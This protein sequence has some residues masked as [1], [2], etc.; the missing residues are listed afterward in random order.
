M[1]STRFEHKLSFCL[2]GFNPSRAQLTC[3]EVI[4]ARIDFETNSTSISLPDQ[5][6]GPNTDPIPLYTPNTNARMVRLSSG[7]KTTERSSTSSYSLNCMGIFKLM[8][9][10]FGASYTN[11]SNLMTDIES[12]IMSSTSR[13]EAVRHVKILK[14]RTEVS[15]LD[16][17]S[18]KLVLDMIGHNPKIGDQNCYVSTGCVICME[19]YKVG[20]VVGKCPCGHDFH[21]VCINEWYHIK[22]ECPL[23]RNHLSRSS[24]PFRLLLCL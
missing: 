10:R 18:E 4:R 17:A 3:G 21:G 1:D 20:S 9:K 23:C 16:K 14:V 8:T 12:D 19:D 15:K 13:G 6:I 5:T 7:V 2:D 24:S 22:N 11:Y